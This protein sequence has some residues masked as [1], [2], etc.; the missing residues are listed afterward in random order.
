MLGEI[1][2]AALKPL[3]GS[4]GGGIL[5]TIGRFAGKT[6]GD[7]LENLDY[8]PEEYQ[9][10]RNIRESF[11]LSKA[12]YG[13]PIALIFG[14]ARVSGKII[15]A[16]QVKEVQNSSETRQYFPDS[17]FSSGQTKTI[18]TLIECT[19]F[20][21]FAISICEGELADINR[22]WANDELIDLAKYKFRLYLGSETQLPDPLIAS[23]YG[24]KKMPAFRSLCYAV[25]ED[26]PL[27]DFGGSVPNFSFEVIRKANIT[28]TTTKHSVEDLV[29]SINMIPGSGEF[30]Y[31]T[32]I[33]YK[34]HLTEFGD[35]IQKTPINSHNYHKIANSIQSL[36]QLQIVCPNI[37]WLSPIVCWFA[38]SLDCGNCA[39]KPTVEFN[40]PHTTYSEEWRVGKYSRG[41][42]RLISKDADNNPNYGGSVNDASVLRYLQEIRRRNL[43]I[44]FYPMFFLYINKKPWRGHV[45][46]SPE[47]IIDFFN[48][49]EGYNNF[50]L[51]YARL[52]K[53]HI[54]AFIIG[55]ELIGLTK[56]KDS[57]NNFPA[58][59]EL[60]KLAEMVKEIVGAN[61]L[62]SYAAD[63]S[64]YHH[65]E[66]GWH[67]MD[68]PFAC[69]YIDFI[70]ID[71][72]FPVTRTS[73]SAIS[74]EEIA[75]GWQSGEGYDFCIDDS[76]GLQK[77]LTPDYA[78]NNL[79]YWWENPHR[80]PDGQYT[81]W[82]PKMK[83]I[84]F[85]EFGFPS[86][87]K[88][89]N[90]PNVFFDPLCSDGGSP[91]YSI[92]GRLIFQFS[93]KLFEDLLNTGK[94]KNM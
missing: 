18:R 40:D 29:Q 64:E 65:T 31:D 53:D 10:F 80:N 7:Y 63:W 22:V 79:K 21:S 93:A 45:T 87:D 62:V 44:M 72:Y 54:D 61:V 69:K 78:W 88:A 57:D 36:N 60:I 91:L 90:Q 12:E 81:H 71:A 16:S 30:V 85:T 92:L 86:I 37:K 1:F 56:V 17:L 35:I 42:A 20:L 39:I 19:Y 27:E 15:W 6:I 73:S 24:K 59:T 2:G 82:Q 49:G 67:N 47:A 89:S 76:D 52:V 83:K 68:A 50:I 74:Q 5:S 48:K 25:F 34:T 94:L 77:P 41:S 32:T 11:H 23:I 84:W 4:L 75:K 38:D 28:L 8:E 9:R 33:Q 43:K 58:V 26:L 14:S 66:G 46:G 55:S 13:Q 3:G 51:H 70:G